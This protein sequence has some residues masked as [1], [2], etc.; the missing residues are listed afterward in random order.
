MPTD[1]EPVKEYSPPRPPYAM[2][3]SQANRQ[4]AD[5]DSGTDTI[6]NAG[7]IQT[8]GESVRVPLM[9]KGQSQKKD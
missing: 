7:I 6:Q 1:L 9:P 8:K 2:P 5:N 3:K 4:K